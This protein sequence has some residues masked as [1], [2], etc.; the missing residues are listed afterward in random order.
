M[1][2]FFSFIE[3]PVETRMRRKVWFSGA[4]I[5]ADFWCC[6]VSYNKMDTKKLSKPHIALTK[7]Y[8]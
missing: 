5:P 3:V 1:W 2:E 4:E 8:E 6:S 7:T